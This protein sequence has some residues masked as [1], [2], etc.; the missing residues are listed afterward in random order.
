MRAS[1]VVAGIFGTGAVAV[2]PEEARLVLRITAPRPVAAV[3]ACG[4]IGCGFVVVEYVL[5]AFR[6]RRWVVAVSM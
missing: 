6:G 2:V 5:R 1:V 3:G 4:A